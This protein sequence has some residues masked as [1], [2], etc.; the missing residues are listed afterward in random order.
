MGCLNWPVG[1]AQECSVADADD[2]GRG[3][4]STCPWAIGCAFSRLHFQKGMSIS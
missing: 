3:I 2:E 4:G 1:S